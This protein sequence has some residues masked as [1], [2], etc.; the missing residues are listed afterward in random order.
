[1][2]CVQHV[3]VADEVCAKKR[4]PVR[5]RERLLA[6][7]A[8][9][10]CRRDDTIFL[11]ATQTAPR[12]GQVEP[13][14]TKHETRLQVFVPVDHIVSFS[15]GSHERPSRHGLARQVDEVIL[16]VRSRQVVQRF[17][18]APTGREA[19][20]LLER[21]LVFC[22]TPDL[23]PFLLANTAVESERHAARLRHIFASVSA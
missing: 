16:L 23:H 11:V 17:L 20:G 14:S 6:H 4:K 13:G 18:Q 3:D 1:M 22:L 15:L 19:H 8:K 7:S 5:H 12:S 9:R 10:G 21:E 2:R